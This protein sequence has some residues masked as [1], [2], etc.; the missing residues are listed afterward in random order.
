MKICN[1]I[2]K[3]KQQKYQHYLSGKIDKYEYFTG[4]EIL[5]FNQRKIIEQANFAFSPLGKAFE[6]Q[7]KT[8]EDQG[9]KQ[10]E[11]LKALKQE[12]KQELESIEGI[13]PENMRTVEVKN[14]IDKIIK[15]EEENNW[16][17]FEYKSNDFETINLKQQD[18][19][20]KVFM[21][22]KLI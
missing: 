4:K 9:T 19:L 10:V 15:W 1:A 16:K 22:V 11:A 17:D 18:L 3:E 5:L 6:N 2:L 7:R 13:F 8:V 20:V 12:D 14:K 21:L